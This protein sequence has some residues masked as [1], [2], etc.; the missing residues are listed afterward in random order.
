[1]VMCKA[2]LEGARV[3]RDVPGLRILERVGVVPDELQRGGTKRH[4]R[5]TVGR[6]RNALL[7]CSKQ[8]LRLRMPCPAHRRLS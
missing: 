8:Y 7:C 2:Y 4:E 6:H 5:P 1:M 3:D